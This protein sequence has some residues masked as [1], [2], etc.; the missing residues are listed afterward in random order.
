MFIAYHIAYH[1]YMFKFIVAHCIIAVH[2][3]NCHENKP[4]LCMSGLIYNL[5]H[6]FNSFDYSPIMI[7]HNYY[8][9]ICAHLS[10]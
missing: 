10:S 1:S 2:C 4:L 5:F 8:P 7:L 9:L 3:D 6:Q